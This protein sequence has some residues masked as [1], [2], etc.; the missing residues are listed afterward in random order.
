MSYFVIGVEHLVF[1]IDHVL[2]VIGLFL[3]I[4][5]PIA[6]IKTIT[7][8]TLSHSITLA[9]SVLEP[10]KLDQG[11]TGGH[12]L[13]YF[14]W[15]G[16]WFKKSTSAH[17]YS[18]TSLGHGIYFRTAARPWPGRWQILDCPRTIFGYHCCCLTLGSK[19]GK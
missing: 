14:L 6:L 17:A 2:F 15:P 12:R 8:F 19:P 5:D 3:F 4:R 18:R 7:A 10:V 11:P 1:G 9:L 16:N 13:V